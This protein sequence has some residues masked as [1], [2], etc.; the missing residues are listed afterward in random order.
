MCVVKGGYMCGK[1]WAHMWQR[2]Y[3]VGI[4]VV[5]GNGG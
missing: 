4:C 5:K 1:G 2:V 3:R